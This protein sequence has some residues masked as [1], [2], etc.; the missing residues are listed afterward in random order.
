[1]RLIQDAEKE[2]DAARKREAQPFDEGKA[3][4]QARYNPLIQTGKGKTT[5]AIQACKT[6]LAPWLKHVDDEN[7][8]KAEEA[9]KVA[10]DAQRVALA[11]FRERDAANLE[12]TEAA[13]ALLAEA[14]HAEAAATKAEKAKAQAKGIGR[15][16]SL[17]TYYTAEI[18]DARAF[19]SFVWTEHRDEM[20]AFLDTLAKRLVDAGKHELPGVTVHED[21]RVA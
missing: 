13:E 2:A 1:M 16:A 20:R 11:A 4:V 19:A 17:R 9:R 3:E 8:R 14:K 21:R 15:A 5:L 6:A 18:I 10:E 12:Q 7:R